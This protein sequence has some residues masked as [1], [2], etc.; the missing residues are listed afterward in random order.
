MNPS[1]GLTPD[2]VAALKAAIVP[3]AKPKRNRA[4]EVAGALVIIAVVVVACVGIF[5]AAYWDPRHR[6]VVVLGGATD[7]PWNVRV[8]GADAKCASLNQVRGEPAAVCELVMPVGDHEIS[9]RGASGKD[10]FHATASIAK[11]DDV[12][13]WAPEVP[14]G[15]CMF[16]ETLEYQ[17]VVIPVGFGAAGPK[18]ERLEPG[19]RNVGK[20]DF[21]FNSAPGRIQ[22]HE[23]EDTKHA[24]RLVACD[25]DPP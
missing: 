2:E 15:L 25:K 6:P 1:N 21:W 9:V 5:E 8:D 18:R 11:G 7:T 19:F 4:V 22:S 23:K 16:R 24:I 13:L 17:E 12:Y 10:V 3:S 14:A 20:V